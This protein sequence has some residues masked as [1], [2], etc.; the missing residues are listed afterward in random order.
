M[1]GYLV[2]TAVG[3]LA[4]QLSHFQKAI[5]CDIAKGGAFSISDISAIALASGMTY[6]PRAKFVKIPGLDTEQALH[7]LEP[8]PQKLQQHGMLPHAREG[9]SG[10]DRWKPSL[11]DPRGH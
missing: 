3:M 5:S 2:V 10:Y 6:D 11:A 7:L 1:Q 4:K 8:Y 9:D